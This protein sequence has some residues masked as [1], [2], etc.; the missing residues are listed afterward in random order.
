MGHRFGRLMEYGRQIA[1]MQIPVHASHACFFMVLSLFPVLLLVLGILRYTPLEAADLM[2]LISGFLPDALEVYAW[3]LI[4]G[5]YRHTSRLVVSVSALT[6]LWSAGR[7]V[8]GLQN[9]LNAVYGVLERRGWLVQRLVCAAYT[10]LFLAAL[11]VTL[12][13]HVFGLGLSALGR[14]L[15]FFLLAGAQTGLFCAMFMYLPAR[16]SGFWESLPGAMLASVGWMGFSGL[17][18]IYVEHFSGLAN[19]YGSVYALALG[20][21]WLYGCVSILFYG[22]ALNRYLMTFS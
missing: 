5:V 6:A 2:V 19:V 4:S 14:E 11:V 7:G 17:F 12:A 18:S 15:G 9:G 16:R 1:G 3:D 20:M 21:L 13:L 22:G 10:L 8:Y